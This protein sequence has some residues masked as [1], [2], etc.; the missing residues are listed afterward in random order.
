MQAEESSDEQRAIERKSVAINAIATD[1]EEGFRLSCTIRD[2]S[3]DGCRVYC[4]EAHSLPDEFLLTPS[5]LK[6]PLKVE[7]RWRHGK[8]VGCRL[9]W[10]DAKLIG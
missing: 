8:W 6:K 10:E 1:A 7:V 5:G 9:N 4:A 3:R 2:A